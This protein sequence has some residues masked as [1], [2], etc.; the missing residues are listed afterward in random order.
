[1]DLPS[2]LKES[3]ISTVQDSEHPEE[4]A[5]AVINLLTITGDRSAEQYERN[6]VLRNCINLVN[7]AETSGD[8]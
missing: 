3:V 6:D 4:L 2:E 5:A 8:N 1:M 7:P